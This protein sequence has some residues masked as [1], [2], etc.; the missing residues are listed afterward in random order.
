MGGESG[1]KLRWPMGSLACTAY[2]DSCSNLNLAI[3]SLMSVVNIS[4]AFSFVAFH[5]MT[6]VVYISVGRS[7]ACTL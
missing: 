2:G 1:L 4:V 7:F 5:S 6:S 3:Y